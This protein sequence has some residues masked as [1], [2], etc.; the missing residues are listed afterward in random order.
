MAEGP[1]RR[2]NG[3]F[4]A[5]D[6]LARTETA[7]VGKGNPVPERRRF[8]TIPYGFMMIGSA[9]K[10]LNFTKKILHDSLRREF[11]SH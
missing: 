8:G 2:L 11:V 4:L 6:L 3:D 7:L 10:C 1:A 5:G 9:L